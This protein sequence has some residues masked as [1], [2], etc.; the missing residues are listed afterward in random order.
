MKK[1]NVYI[2]LSTIML[3]VGAGKV[4][5]APV[6]AY[7]TTTSKSATLIVS[8]SEHIG[9]IYGTFSCGE[10]G[11]TGLTYV[12]SDSP[13]TSKS[14]TISW[15]KGSGD[16]TCSVSD[17]QVGTL[18]SASE[19]VRGYSVKSKSVSLGSSSN[20]SGGSSG[21]SSNTK[22]S[23]NNYKKQKT[24]S[25]NNYLSRYE[26]E[27]FEISPKFDKNTTDYTLT[28][29]N[30]TKEIRIIQETEDD[31]ASVSGD[32][33]TI[34]L[35][36]EENKFSTIVTA[37]D[38]SKRTYNITIKVEA[39][40]IIVKIDNKEFNVVKNKDELPKLELEHEDMTLTIQDQEVP[41]YRIDSISYVLIGLRDSDGKVNLY[42]FDSFKNDEK[43]PTYNLFSYIEGKKILLI[44]KEFAANKIPKN[45][46]KYTEKINGNEYS[47][48]K[49]NKNSNYCLLYGI[50]IE[51]GK[52][53]IYKY[54][55]KE[56]TLQIYDNEEQKELEKTT[57]KYEKLILILAGVVVFLV[58]LTT[59]GFTRKQKVKDKE[60]DDDFLTKKD[61]KKIEKETKK[62]DKKNKKQNE[63][64]D[65]EFLT[66]KE[67]KKE[68]KKGKKKNKIEE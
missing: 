16:Y 60:K 46:K 20:S 65:M 35:K 52:E 62:E 43:E 38:G 18:E 56:K 15:N 49:L 59:I 61:I 10:L 30:G 4:K 19:G 27:N 22:T 29:P 51:T 24:K 40:P 28:V 12:A 34:E 3:C 50:N 53:N 37:E 31:K 41:A 9:Q 17:F 11:S 48:Y 5:A 55:L 45:Y 44:N 39:K 2:I 36:E 58:L 6:N 14:Y 26:I 67:N 25:S 64:I 47:V 42:K 33:G 21:S 23:N 54:D 32:D 63:N 8:S 68:K 13:P 1:I 66:K 7:I 57:E